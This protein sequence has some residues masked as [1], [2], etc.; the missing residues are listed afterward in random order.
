M[1]DLCTGSGA[2]AKALADEVPGRRR[3]RRRARRGGVR[4]G[5]AQPGRH[6]RRP[7]A[8]RRVHR[9][10]RP[11]RPG[12]R[13]GLQPAVRPARGVGVGRPR[14]ARPRPAPGP[15]LRR[16][17]PGRDPAC[18]RSGAA[19]LL[20]PG[21]VRRRRARRRPGRGGA[22]RCSR[23]PAAGPRC[24]TTA[25]SR[26]V[27]GS[28][29]P[30]WHHEPR[31]AALPDRPPTRSARPRSRPPASPSSAGA[32]WC[33]RPTPSTGWPPTPSTRT[34]S[35]SCSTPRAAAARCRRRCWSRRR[36]R[37][38]RSRSGCRRWARALVEEFWPG[39]LTLVCHAHA[40][41]QWD[42]GDTRGTVAVRMPDHPVAL[43]ILER[44]GPLAVSSANLTGQPAATERRPGRGDARRGG[45]GA[46]RRR[47]VA[48]RRGLDD[49]R[50][51]LHAG[52]GAPR[53]GAQPRAA[54]RGARAAG[55]RAARPRCARRRDATRR[56]RAEDAG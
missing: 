30:D 31:C 37:S 9:V 25:T 45:R 49:R 10:R 12:R 44:T 32:S 48:G 52:P 18:W 7:A 24:A 19:E 8:G 39:A 28:P 40:S 42:L 53:G 29:P 54:Q 33:C 55:R 41:L 2:I 3:P 46:R 5:R 43:E 1:V 47:H 36:P 34:R 14:G 20:R 22:R 56:R 23:P 16:R 15:V 50:R 11:A 21:G 6:R 35:R 38:T 17:R 27:L 13:G 51:D 26:A 4:L